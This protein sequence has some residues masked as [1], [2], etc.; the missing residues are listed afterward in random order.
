MPRFSVLRACVGRASV[1]P[2]PVPRV[3]VRRASGLRALVSAA[4]LGLVVSACAPVVSSHGVPMARIELASI[5]PGLDT[6][7]TVRRQLGRPI[8]T[9]AIDGD[10]WFYISSI[11]EREMF[12]APRVVE[13]QVLTVRFDE[14]GVVERVGRYA[15]ED[16]RVV[17][18]R[19][20]TTPTFGRELTIVQQLFGNI[21]RFTPEQLRQAN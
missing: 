15:L 10:T 19:P 8:H 12:Y 4:A 3:P 17:S 6:R 14:D 11:M 7:G 1:R 21:A 18:L 2:T 16:G 5:E 9:S 13:R 20:E